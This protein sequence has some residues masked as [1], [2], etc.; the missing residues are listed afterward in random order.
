MRLGLGLSLSA[1]I[2][3]PSG[4]PVVVTLPGAPT[5]GTVTADNGFASIQI[6]DGAAGTY[7]L[8]YRQIWTGPSAESLT[9]QASYPVDPDDGGVSSV[10]IPTTVGVETFFCVIMVDN[11]GNSGP[12]SSTGSTTGV[13]APAKITDLSRDDDLIVWT[14]PTNNGVAI[15]DY[16]KQ[17]RAVGATTWT[18]P[19]T[20]TSTDPEWTIPTLDDGNYEVRVAAVNI[21]QGEWS[22]PLTITIGTPSEYPVVASFVP[23]TGIITLVSGDPEGTFNV[24]ADG[25]SV[26]TITIGGTFD[27]SAYRGQGIDI[28]DGTNASALY[29]ADP[30][31][32]PIYSHDYSGDA[33]GTSLTGQGWTTVTN[34]TIIDGTVSRN[35]TSAANLRR[36]VGTNFVDVTIGYAG[37]TSTVN[38]Q[39]TLGTSGNNYN[40][41]AYFQAGGVFMQLLNGYTQVIRSPVSQYKYFTPN[42]SAGDIIRVRT[43]VS[44]GNQ[45]AQMYVNGVPLLDGLGMDWT[46]YTLSSTLLRIGHFNSETT[47]LPTPFMSSVNIVDSSSPSAFDLVSAAITGPTPDGPATAAIAY[48]AGGS[49]TDIET[50]IVDATGKSLATLGT[51]EQT[52]ELTQDIP[53]EAYGSNRFLLIRD[54]DDTGS[55]SKLP[56]GNI[57]YYAPAAE[58]FYYGVNPVDAAPWQGDIFEDRGLQASCDYYN[59][60]GS[61][62]PFTNYPVP[63]NEYGWPTGEI[64]AAA[65]A[66]GAVGIQFKYM[67][68]LAT[69][70]G[71]T[72]AYTIEQMF[73]S[74]SNWTVTPFF[75]TSWSGTS[76]SGGVGHYTIVDADETAVGYVRCLSANPDGEAVSGGIRFTVTRDDSTQSDK[77]LNEAATSDFPVLKTFRLYK[78][79]QRFNSKELLTVP[80]TEWPFVNQRPLGHP[81]IVNRAAAQIGAKFPSV[82]FPA[83]GE[84]EYHIR[85]ALGWAKAWMDHLNDEGVSSTD[86][87]LGRCGIAMA[88]EVWNFGGYQLYYRP[89]WSIASLYG[90]VN[91]DR[92][93]CIVDEQEHL[94]VDGTAATPV[95]LQPLA[96]G[97]RVVVAARDVTY[98]PDGFPDGAPNQTVMIEALV[99]CEAGEPLP[100]AVRTTGATT[101]NIKIAA[102]VGLIW[103]CLFRCVAYLVPYLTKIMNT[104]VVPDDDYYF[105]DWSSLSGTGAAMG[106]AAQPYLEVNKNH[107]LAELQDML[108][109]DG[110]LAGNENLR[111][112]VEQEP[113]IGGSGY[114][115]LDWAWQTGGWWDIVAT[116]TDDPTRE[117]A[118]EGFIAY[119]KAASDNTCG[120]IANHR[121]WLY[122]MCR[123]L[124]LEWNIFHVLYETGLHFAMNS[125]TDV[126]ATNFADFLTY[127]FTQYGMNDLAHYHDMGMRNTGLDAICDFMMYEKR[128][129]P[130]INSTAH[131]GT[132]QN[133]GIARIPGTSLDPTIL[134]A[135]QRLA[136]TRRF[137]DDLAALEGA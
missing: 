78:W 65:K 63:L 13:A 103:P 37:V 62:S 28:T 19:L 136:G 97:Q 77:I 79:T 42:L 118:M 64:T 117:T 67:D 61:T 68:S 24:R 81:A 89:L 87:Y 98:T 124:G 69:G 86:K 6:I 30:E 85:H 12:A 7:P 66:A 22:D 60:A 96:A 54:A 46:G 126:Q 109:Y 44:G 29:Y 17:Y 59:S 38:L 48:T 100:A 110:G 11:H 130:T 20:P 95:L 16:R 84:L 115:F 83:F 52:G 108:L 2:G 4:P 35:S 41:V 14:A 18:D 36:D 125:A 33:D 71:Q 49:V 114:A 51:H 43:Y 123:D 50:T 91:E 26:G 120:K 99:D 5:I 122:D 72:G 25:V 127:A 88:N 1:G 10:T 131:T 31:I 94:Y 137:L 76:W 15:T 55:F 21:W 129:T 135:S 132:Y 111:H 119:M 45:Y 82:C 74:G 27:T 105:G 34:A 104:N 106:G 116:A 112:L 47:T 92:L 56:L 9:L 73:D 93:P 128:G 32:E 58:T 113:A 70:P 90:F 3:R 57:Q 102:G 75:A 39:V 40:I 107:S 133:F 134:A 8:A 80:K 23:S 53:E 121:Q 101:G